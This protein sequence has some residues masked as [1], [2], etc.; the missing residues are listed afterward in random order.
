[1][2]CLLLYDADD[3]IRKPV[4]T[5]PLLG[6]IFLDPN[7]DTVVECLPGCCSDPLPSKYPAILAAD[8]L[9]SRL[10]ATYG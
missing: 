1:V 5:R 8:Y 3:L 9:T 2:V 7:P 4:L 6:R 10:R